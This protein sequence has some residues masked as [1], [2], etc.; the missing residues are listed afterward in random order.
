MSHNKLFSILEEDEINKKFIETIE[1]SSNPLPYL[2]VKSMEML[3]DNSIYFNLIPDS[4]KKAIVRMTN[5]CYR[6]CYNTYMDIFVIDKVSKATFDKTL[7]YGEIEVYKIVG[8]DG[9]RDATVKEVEQGVRGLIAENIYPA[10]KEVN[11]YLNLM[12]WAFTGENYYFRKAGY[13]LT[14][15]D[16][17]LIKE[18]LYDLI[19]MSAEQLIEMFKFVSDEDRY[20]KAVKLLNKTR[21]NGGYKYATYAQDEVFEDISIKQLVR[22]ID[23]VMPRHSDNGDYRRAISLVIKTNK[24]NIRLTPLEISFLRRIYSEYTSNSKNENMVDTDS[25][26]D[27]CERLLKMQY[28][29]LIDPKHFAY[30][31]INTIKKNNYSRCSS[32][33]ISYIDQAI[34]IIDKGNA[35]NIRKKADENKESMVEGTKYPGILSDDDIDSMLNNIMV[36]GIFN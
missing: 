5:M 25:L 31:I 20:N 4:D 6:N 10:G 36:N 26:R 28:S 19:K 3:A 13:S 27:K 30:T 16:N 24:N 15:L 8:R 2:V 1:T 29:G 12:M 32:K 9:L 17:K 22:N 34:A 23:S 7:R 14:Y 18:S 35:E 33:Q 11:S 21:R